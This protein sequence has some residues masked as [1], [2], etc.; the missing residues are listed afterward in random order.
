LDNSGTVWKDLVADA[1]SRKCVFDATNDTAICKLI[2]HVKHEFDEL[3]DLLNPDSAVF[4]N[5][6]WKVSSYV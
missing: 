3:D 1:Q 2:L 5:T 6:R 4:S